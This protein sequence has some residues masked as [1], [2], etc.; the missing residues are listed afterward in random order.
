MKYYAVK[1]GNETGIFKTWEE[2]KVAIAGYKGAKFKSFQSEEEAIAFM[3]GQD[4]WESKVLQD[5]EAGYLVI[6]SDGSYDDEIKKY[7][8]GAVIIGPG[9]KEVHLSANGNNEKYISSRNVI[10]EVLG[11]LNGLNWALTKGFT[12]VKVYHDYEGLSKWADGEWFA[13]SEVGK[14]YISKYKE[15]F[16]GKIDVVFEKVKGHSNSKYN[17]IADKLAKE[18]LK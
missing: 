1:E 14:M 15:R 11:V 4:F 8:Y 18:A 5:I 10:G 9:L 3:E 6:F 12:K 7:S 16:V 2:C 17:D 13:K